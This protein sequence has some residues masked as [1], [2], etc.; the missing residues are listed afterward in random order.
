[1]SLFDIKGRAVLITGAS[2][3]IGKALAIG[4]KDAGA[5]V[6]GTGS[7]EESIAWMKDEDIIGRVADVSKSGTMTP[8]IEEIKLNYGKLSC[9]INNAGIASNTPAVGFKDDEIYKI[10]DTNFVGVF[11]AC[12]AYY[13]SHKQ[14]GGNII[15]VASVLGLRGYSLAS[16][17][18]G[19]KGASIQLARALGAE[20]VKNNFRANV[21]CPGFIE[22]D[23]NKMIRD[24][25]QVYEAVSESVP[26]K[27]MGKPEDI[28]GTAIYLASDASSYITGQIISVDGGL[29]TLMR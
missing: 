4:F 9:L 7:R 1:M 10:I 11:R 2:R 6:Y 23:M 13:K 22:T 26:M 18:S 15:N 21:I 12:Q 19:T 24:K 27:R 20:W 17:Y 29:S 3:G 5:I 14:I 28:V 8:I 16:I 25:P